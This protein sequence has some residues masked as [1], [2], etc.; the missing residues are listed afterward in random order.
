MK[1]LSK[2]LFGLDLAGAICLTVGMIYLSEYSVKLFLPAAMPSSPEGAGS[3]AA[4]AIFGVA[5][6]LAVVAIFLLLISF[7]GM[8]IGLYSLIAALCCRRKVNA[9][10]RLVA[11]KSYLALQITSSAL[12]TVVACFT[13]VLAFSLTPLC[14][15]APVLCAAC[16]GCTAAGAALKFRYLRAQADGG[17]SP[18]Q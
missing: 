14:F 3:G 12:Q 8:A 18:A 15:P 6:A 2:K 17:A 10:G 13:I 7:I 16:L 5:F 1:H 4:I 11:K 9:E